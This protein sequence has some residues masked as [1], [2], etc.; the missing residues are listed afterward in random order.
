MDRPA[1]IDVRFSEEAQKLLIVFDAQPTDRAGMNGVGACAIVLSD[2]TVAL[3]RGTGDAPGCYWEDSRTLVAPLDIYTTAA[4][5][6][7]IEV[8]GGVVCYEGDATLCAAATARTV[9]RD[10]QP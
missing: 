9:P 3:L 7:R 2:A 4:P 5:G 10:P 1:L 6:M 8:R